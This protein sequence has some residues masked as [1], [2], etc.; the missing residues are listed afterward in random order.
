MVGRSWRRPVVGALREHGLKLHRACSLIG[1]SENGYRYKAR[2]SQ[3]N[4]VI[5]KRMR[6]I[7]RRHP[8]YGFPRLH[9]LI[10]R[11]IQKVNKKRVHRIYVQNHLQVRHR[12]RWKRKLGVGERGS[13]PQAERQNQIWVMDFIEDRLLSGKKYRCLNIEDVYTRELLEC[14]VAFSIGG[15]RVTRVLDM[16]CALRGYPERIVTDN[17][18]EF[19]SRAMLAWTSQNRVAHHFIDPGKPMQNGYMESLNGR[20]RDEHMNAQV[21]DT[22]QEARQMVEDWKNHYNNERPHSSLKYLTPRE[23]AVKEAVK[24]TLESTKKMG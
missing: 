17:G 23:Y 8:R 18:S 12:R 5:L 14:D 13:L 4:E 1:L 19:T 9:Y 3:L 15:A 22:L 16:V 2:R 6:E 11:D 24:L 21:P 10:C 20:M 7:T